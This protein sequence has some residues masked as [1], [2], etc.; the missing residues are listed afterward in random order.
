MPLIAPGSAGRHRYGIVLVLAIAM[1]VFLIVA[2]DRNGS[3]SVGL[4][5]AGLMLLT[6]VVTSRA[7]DRATR[8]FAA[9]VLIVLTVAL[10]VT[11]AAGVVPKWVASATA[12][13]LVIVTLV[14]LVRGVARLL[15]TEGVTVQAV[16]GALAVYLLLGVLYSLVIAVAARLGHGPYFAQGIDGT[17]S[18]HVYFSFTTMTTTG[19]GDLSPATRGGRALAVLEMLTGQIYLVTVIGLLVGN[20]RRRSESSTGG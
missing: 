6:V 5:V 19:F 15:R 17:E 20:L 12:G 11:V 9:A 2:P 1:V 10:G 18:Q 3:R 7:G 13:L 4:G 16:V 14:Q 8:G